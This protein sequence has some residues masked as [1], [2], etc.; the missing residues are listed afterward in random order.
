MKSDQMLFGVCFSEEGDML[1]QWREYANKGTGL[2]I[3]FD[4]KWFQW[5]CRD[6][7]FMFSKVTYGYGEKNADIVK[8]YAISIYNEIREI[9]A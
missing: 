4:A 6:E 9:R 7:M 2:A 1:G 3:G 8:K 5:L